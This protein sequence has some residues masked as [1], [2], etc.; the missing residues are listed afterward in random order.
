MGWMGPESQL[1]QV[2]R[3]A[4]C[5]RAKDGKF[6]VTGTIVSFM[7]LGEEFVVGD[8]AMAFI[9]GRPVSIAGLFEGTS[10]H[11]PVKVI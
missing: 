7:G 5:D 1:L 6:R 2:L 9:D 8:D 10:Y 3:I 11:F 4:G